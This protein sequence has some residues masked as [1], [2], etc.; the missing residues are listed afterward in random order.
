[1]KGTGPNSRGSCSTSSCRLSASVESGITPPSRCPIYSGQ[2]QHLVSIKRK[3]FIFIFVPIR[4]LNGPFPEFFCSVQLLLRNSLVL[5]IF[6]LYDMICVARFVI[7]FIVKNPLTI[8][9]D[10][11]NVFIN[12]WTFGMSHLVQFVFVMLPGR[13]PINYYICSGTSMLLKHFHS[14]LLRLKYFF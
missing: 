5:Q 3:Q 12:I 4:Y 1:M 13:Q 11:W 7:I 2:S 8:Q 6:L 10:F 9:D 14:K